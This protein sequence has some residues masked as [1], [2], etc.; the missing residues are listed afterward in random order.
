MTG[1]FLPAIVAI[2]CLGAAACTSVGEGGPG[3]AAVSS[4]SNGRQASN[5]DGSEAWLIPSPVPGTPMRATLHR[6]AGPGPFP[7]A[8]VNHGSEQDPLRRSQM[9]LP[10]F[11]TITAWLLARNYAVLIPQ[12]PGHGATG[13]RYLEDQGSCNRAD[14]AAAGNGTADSIAAAVAFMRSQPFILPDDVVA[15]GNSAGGW[16]ALALAARN[17]PGVAGI[18]AFAPGRGGR[19]RDR[20]GENCSP[21]RL[22]AAA[23]TF[24]Q[25]ARVPVLMLYAENDGYFPPALSAQIGEAFRAAGGNVTFRLLPP[26]GGEGHALIDAP[27]APWTADVEAFLSG[28]N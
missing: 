3:T 23:G 19:D 13:G 25:T 20:P 16:G 24:G 7:L 15:I 26:V 27:S 18:V 4:Q 9:G 10:A 5:P 21:E 8:V 6:P 17:P 28:L 1:R 11:P 12:R 14:Y 22:V 2:V